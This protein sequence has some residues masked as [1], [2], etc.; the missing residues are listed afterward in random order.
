[1]SRNVS[2]VSQVDKTMSER[3]IYARVVS[4]RDKCV[5]LTPCD[6][7]LLNGHMYCLSL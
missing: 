2:L 6:V 7:S 4:C 3:D 5:L 1:M